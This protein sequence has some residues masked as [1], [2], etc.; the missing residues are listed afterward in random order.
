MT[1]AQAC[2]VPETLTPM[3]M[4]F[5]HDNWG[6]SLCFFASFKKIN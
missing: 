3:I 6:T 2:A 4:R 1:F 5:L